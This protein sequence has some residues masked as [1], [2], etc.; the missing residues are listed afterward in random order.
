VVQPI[1]GC[2]ACESCDAGLPNHCNRRVTIGVHADGGFAERVSVPAGNVYALPEDVPLDTAALLQPFAIATYA[3]E[4]AGL[5]PDDRIGVWG[6]GQIGM[7][8]IQ[9]AMLTGVRVEFAVGRDA[10]RLEAAREVGAAATFSANDGDPSA[11]LLRRFGKDKVDV[12][13]EVSGHTPAINSALSIL[14]K[15]GRAVLIGNLNEPFTGDLLQ[16]VMDQI[17]MLS[18]RSYSLSA[19]RRALSLIGRTQGQRGALPVCQVPLA[20]GAR[21]FERAASGEGSKFVLVP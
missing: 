6:V 11:A 10:A 4:I 16:M 13:F 9:I 1:V 18:V 21:A 20:D 5:K 19:W 2:G 3:V 15:R 14:K 8:I 17:S 7:S 12:V